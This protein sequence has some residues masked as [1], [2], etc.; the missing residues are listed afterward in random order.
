MARPQNT[1]ELSID[2]LRNDLQTLIVNT[3]SDRAYLPEALD[4]GINLVTC[5]A[6]GSS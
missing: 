6:S 3:S 4:R 1:F 5:P 2:P